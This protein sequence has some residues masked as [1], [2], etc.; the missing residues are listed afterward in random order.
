MVN[1]PPRNGTLLNIQGLLR[2][3]FHLEWMTSLMLYVPSF[4]VSTLQSTQ[5][6][7][8]PF[9]GLIRCS[10]NHSRNLTSSGLNIQRVWSLDS[11]ASKKPLRLHQAQ[12]RGRR[13]LKSTR[14]RSAPSILRYVNSYSFSFWVKTLGLRSANAN[15]MICYD[16]LLNSR[17][18]FELLWTS[19]QLVLLMSLQ[20]I[21]IRNR[22]FYSKI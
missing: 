2:F 21:F 15:T 8:I 16:F 14:T 5:F 1:G 19:T 4:C 7:S 13:S 18:C 17:N 3:K 9:R 10:L 22:D 12:R 6:M 11:K 20:K